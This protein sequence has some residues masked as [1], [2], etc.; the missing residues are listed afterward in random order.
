MDNEHQ[1]VNGYI[2]ASNE[3]F[4]CHPRG[5]KEGSFNHSTSVFPLTGAHQTVNC[6]QCHQNGYANTTTVCYECHQTQ[7]NSSTNPNHQTLG[8]STEC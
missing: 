4:S 2:Y 6:S 3:C 1:G 8:I 7:F 5:T